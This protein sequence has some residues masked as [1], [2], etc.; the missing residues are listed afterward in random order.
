MEKLIFKHPLP[1]FFFLEKSGCDPKKFRGVLMNYL[2]K[3]ETLVEKNILV[4]NIESE[5]RD[6]LRELNRKIRGKNEKTVKLL[7]YNNHII[8][9]IISK[10]SS[11]TSDAIHFSAMESLSTSILYDAKIESKIFTLKLLTLCEIRCLKKWIG[12]IFSILK[13]KHTQNFAILTLNKFA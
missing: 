11:N 12:S 5:D 3:F 2:P 13:N 9:S 1:R 4:S 7:R 6:F 8:Y 10:T